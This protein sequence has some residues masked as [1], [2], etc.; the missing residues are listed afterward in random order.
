MGEKKLSYEMY[1]LVLKH[2]IFDGENTYQIEEPLVFKQMFDM[3]FGSVP[4]C[5]REMLD[6]FTAEVMK[7]NIERGK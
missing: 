4:Y 1:T 5:L 2:E 3:R 7:R 6:R